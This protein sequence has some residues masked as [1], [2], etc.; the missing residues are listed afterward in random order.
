MGDEAPHSPKNV[1]K[2]GTC[3]HYTPTPVQRTEAGESSGD[4]PNLECL[5]CRHH[6][7]GPKTIATVCMSTV[8]NGTQHNLKSQLSASRSIPRALMSFSSG[9]TET[10]AETPAEKRGELIKLL[11]H[12]KDPLPAAAQEGPSDLPRVAQ[13]GPHGCKIWIRC[14]CTRD[15]FQGIANPDRG[16]PQDIGEPDVPLWGVTGCDKG[17]DSRIV[18]LGWPSRSYTALALPRYVLNM[19]RADFVYCVTL[20]QV[21]RRCSTG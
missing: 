3:P 18:R 6:L 19:R 21:R 8:R 14:F 11:V 9:P 16:M 13:Q 15:R 12:N 5:V 2:P 17:L 7:G 20:K 10:P 1:H 4:P